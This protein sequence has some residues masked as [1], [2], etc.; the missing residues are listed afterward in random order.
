MD[1]GF[2]AA[3]PD[4]SGGR[5]SRSPVSLEP[6]AVQGSL[7]TDEHWLRL[8]AVEDMASK[9]LAGMAM[10][11]R[12]KAEPALDAVAMAFGPSAP[13]TYPRPFSRPWCPI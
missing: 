8:A 12:P 11:D 9:D 2:S 10:A 6:M 5:T 4:T 3:A 13:G 1:R 7:P